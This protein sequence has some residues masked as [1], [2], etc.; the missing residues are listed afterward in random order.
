MV[1]SV[2]ALARR[3]LRPRWGPVTVANRLCAALA[4]GLSLVASTASFGAMETRIERG[5]WT[6]LRARSVGGAVIAERVVPVTGRAES[7]VE[8][9]FEGPASPTPPSRTEVHDARSDL[10][11][12]IR[13]ATERGAAAKTETVD[14][15]LLYDV[16]MQGIRAER[17]SDEALVYRAAQHSVEGYLADRGGYLPPGIHDYDLPKL[18]QQFGWSERRRELLKDLDPV[19]LQLA[20]YGAREVLLFGSFV[21]GKE[22]PGDIDLQISIPQGVTPAHFLV[23]VERLDRALHRKGIHLVPSARPEPVHESDR[24]GIPKGM[25]RLHLPPPK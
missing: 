21:S 11:C 18:R 3:L 16:A 12:L 23:R 17:P 20:E 6:G 10:Q 24:R 25:I 22:Q 7:R 5:R 15:S 8:T 13:L 4:L 19:L 2:P 9:F 14:P 1:G